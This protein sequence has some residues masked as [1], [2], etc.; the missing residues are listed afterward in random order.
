MDSAIGDAKMLM[1]SRKS[2]QELVLGKNG[3]IEIKVVEIRG[4]KVRLGITAPRD[5]PV[6][7]REVFDAIK[8]R[9]QS[10][11][12]PLA[13]KYVEGEGRWIAESFY[14]D[15]ST[16][17]HWFIEIHRSGL[18]MTMPSDMQMVVC[19]DSCEIAAESLS[20]AKLQ[21]EQMEYQLEAYMRRQGIDIVSLVRIRNE[22]IN[23]FEDME[24]AS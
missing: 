22:R 2:G 19:A 21:C 1:L 3:E 12:T 9:S 14:G 16:R 13:W 20:E 17:E 8:K 11:S 5:I 10:I 6:H 23:A 4:D 24:V 7:R 18:F 15:E